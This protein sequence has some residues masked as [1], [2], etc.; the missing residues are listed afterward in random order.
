MDAFRCSPLFE[1]TTLNIC[2][3]GARRKLSRQISEHDVIVLLHSTNGDTLAY[4]NPLLPELQARNAT[5]CVFVG[6]EVNLPGSPMAEKISFLAR[7]EPTYI[8]TQLPLEAGQWL[9]SDGTASRVV[10]VPHALN[11][12]VFRPE[13]GNRERPIDI[14][15]RSA[16]Y[17]PYIGDDQRNRLFDL[18]TRVE[19]RRDLVIDIDTE[20][21]FPRVEWAE[22][23]NRCKGT[24]S[25]EAG[26]WYLERDDRTVNEIRAYVAGG[27][28]RAG[29]MIPA[30]SPLRK[31]GHKLPWSVRSALRKIMRHGFLR[32]EASVNETLD[33]DEIINRFF[34]KREKAPVYS[35]A[36][37]S[38]HFDAIG[39]KTCQIMI[40][41]RFNNI[42][43][44]DEHYL[45]LEPDFA[46]FQ[47]VLE[48]FRDDSHRQNLVDETFEYVR[49]S[50][51]YDHRL[52]QIRETI[53]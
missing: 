29:Y 38:R 21:R 16:R 12:D 49:G 50:H 48:Q 41:G 14:G 39:T 37:S 53:G 2:E 25:T 7:V 24:V 35:K 20:S 47:D 13:T 22:F 1:V 27:E 18:F 52:R 11:P 19:V 5:L 32:H 3:R 33:A 45:A 42:L 46:N 9:Y 30:D 44:A 26:S 34:K 8:F 6:N 36:I 40:K 28:R 31:L 15:A 4:L 23:L 10:E 43:R 17:T 51:T